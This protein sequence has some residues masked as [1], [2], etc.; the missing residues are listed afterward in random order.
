[1]RGVDEALLGIVLQDE[2]VRILEECVL[3]DAELE[4]GPPLWDTW[5]CPWD[6]L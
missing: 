1:M 3:T 2:I 4:A 6:T 5:A